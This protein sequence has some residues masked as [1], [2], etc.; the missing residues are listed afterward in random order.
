[1]GLRGPNTMELVYMEACRRMGHNLLSLF[2]TGSQSDSGCTDLPWWNLF[3][4]VV[5]ERAAH[6]C[7]CVHEKF[8][9][10]WDFTNMILWNS[11][12]NA[13][14]GTTSV[15]CSINEYPN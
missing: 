13:G 6:N 4:L 15:E 11:Y 12:A 1:M 5:R 7:T 2:T 8:P 3:D 9:F 10:G 14:V